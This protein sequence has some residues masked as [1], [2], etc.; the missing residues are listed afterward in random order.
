METIIEYIRELG[1]SGALTI[2]YM[3][4]Y[5][6]TITPADWAYKPTLDSL[7]KGIEMMFINNYMF[8]M[9]IDMEK[10]DQDSDAFIFF[11]VAQRN[12]NVK[13]VGNTLMIDLKHPK[14]IS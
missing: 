2:F 7:V 11:S 4:D 8:T 13:R 10:A 1:Q 14:Y 12:M 9:H 6:R 5:V 3:S